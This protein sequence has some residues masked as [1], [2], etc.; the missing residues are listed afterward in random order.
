[1]REMNWGIFSG[2]NYLPLIQPCYFFSIWFFCF[3][4]CL[5]VGECDDHGVHFQPF[6]YLVTHTKWQDLL[7]LSHFFKSF[8]H[9]PILSIPSFCSS[10]GLSFSL[11][12]C[13]WLC[14]EVSGVLVILASVTEHCRQEF[15]LC[16]LV[17]SEPCQVSDRDLFASEFCSYY[18]FFFF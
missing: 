3:H 4:A 18:Q 16:S 9:L 11:L 13:L 6:R 7:I 14:G 2:H 10:P 5:V 12:L 1:M 15:S 8:S 17:L